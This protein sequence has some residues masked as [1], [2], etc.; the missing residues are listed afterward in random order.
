MHTMYCG[1]LRYTFQLRTQ[2]PNNPAPNKAGEQG[3]VDV[4]E[5]SKFYSDS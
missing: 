1:I 5:I 2:I 4:N 3:E